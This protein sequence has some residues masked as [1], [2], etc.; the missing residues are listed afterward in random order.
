MDH[1]LGI[2]FGTSNSTVY[3]FKN[4]EAEALTDENGSSLFPSYVMYYNNKVVT[5]LTAKKNMG[6]KDRYVVSCVKRLIGQ[7]YSYYEQLEHRDIFGCEVVEGEDGYPYFVVDA[8]GRRVNCVDVACELFKEFKRRADVYC[9]PRVFDAAY[10]TVP[11]DYKDFQCEKIKEA[12]KRAGLSIKKVIT[13]PAAA[14][15]SWYYTTNCKIQD[16]EKLLVYDFGGGTFDASIMRYTKEE[17][18]V[19]I[20]QAGDPYLGGNDIDL[21][22]SQYIET[23]FQKEYG[24]A[25]IKKGRREWRSRSLLKEKCEEIKLSLAMLPLSDFDFTPFADEEVDSLTVSRTLFNTIIQPLIQK[26]IR[27]V[28]ELLQ[29]NGILPGTIRYFFTIG[30]S[31]RL[32]LVSNL[33]KAMFGNCVFPEVNTQQCVALGAAMMMKAD[34]S[35]T[36]KTIKETLNTSFGLEVDENRVLLM[37][38]RGGNLPLTGKSYLFKN[39]KGEKEI[40]MR[41]F[42]YGGELPPATKTPF[43][44]LEDCRYV[45]NL[46][47]ELPD[48][49][50]V[51]GSFIEIEF[52]MDVGGVLTVNCYNPVE[53]RDLFYSHVYE[54]VY[55]SY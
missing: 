34:H 31:S 44:K 52:S 27:C 43:V 26:T 29:R 10:L 32:E 24:T 42:K 6:G 46:H 20:D 35:S 22:L 37:V 41:I 47:V 5:G 38:K 49:C 30:G 39:S 16:Y 3:V 17:G 51:V 14:A 33:T 1:I 13:E 15:L 19:I 36:A 48:A 40:A 45:Y 53:G 18:F 54:A 21:A 23:A 28:E 2:D 50:S 12:A 4:G 9:H 7:P 8:N 25:L 11:A 55:G